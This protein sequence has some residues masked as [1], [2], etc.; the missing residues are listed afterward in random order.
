MK[1][2]FLAAMPLICLAATMS[3]GNTA[4]AAE[5][6]LEKFQPS[7]AAKQ[8]DGAVRSRVVVAASTAEMLHRFAAFNVDLG[9]IRRGAAGS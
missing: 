8:L 1:T 7:F 6:P 9:E 2:L 5:M 4:I 3:A